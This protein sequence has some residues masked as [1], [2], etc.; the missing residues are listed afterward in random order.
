ML[1]ILGR[2]AHTALTWGS[3][4]RGGMVT[5]VSAAFDLGSKSFEEFLAL[6]RS[7]AAIDAGLVTADQLLAGL[8]G[9]DQNANG[10]LCVQLPHGLEVSASPAAPYSYNVVDDNA[11]AP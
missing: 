11:S 8:R 4:Q 5:R 6:P 1:Y 10:L 9:I 7:Q 2:H 3:R